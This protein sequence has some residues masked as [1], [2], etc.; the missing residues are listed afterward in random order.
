MAPARATRA[1][2]TS[3]DPVQVRSSAPR[4]RAP[5]VLLVV[6]LALFG[7]LVARA[8]FG[9]QIDQLRTGSVTAPLDAAEVA[10]VTVP[11][12]VRLEASRPGRG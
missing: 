5:A 6:A 9:A 10:A 8:P 2:C 3:P 11:D 4:G 12:E 1:P 7:P